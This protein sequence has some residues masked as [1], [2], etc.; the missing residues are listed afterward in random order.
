MSEYRSTKDEEYRP[1]SAW[2]VTSAASVFTA[3]LVLFNQ[4]LLIL[5]VLGLL[6]ASLAY[7]RIQSSDTPVA[8]AKMVL[9][10]AALITLITSA[11]TT[12]TAT[13]SHR[14]YSLARKYSEQ[15]FDYILHKD[16][17]RAHQM[18]IQPEARVNVNRDDHLK[19]F[20]DPDFVLARP[21]DSAPEKPIT[22][23]N[24]LITTDPIV[25]MRRL[26]DSV[27]IRYLR[28]DPRS[29]HKEFDRE[30]FTVVFEMTPGPYFV[31]EPMEFG[32]QVERRRF[33][34]PV[35]IQWR[36]VKQKYYSGGPKQDIVIFGRPGITEGVE[37]SSPV[38]PPGKK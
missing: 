2:A 30:I 24:E 19:A 23:L 21:R 17:Y 22:S 31:N 25:S 12:Y 5:P 3:P 32:L 15:W 18:T 33:R 34:P 9:V 11:L 20:Y 38:T 10:S 8:G 27:K 28:T 6:L 26:G 35:G 29:Y 1:L 37:D 16:Y 4:A 7:R 13:R 36:V 14:M